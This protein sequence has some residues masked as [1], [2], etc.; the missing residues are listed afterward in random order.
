MPEK[1]QNTKGVPDEETAITEPGVTRKLPEN[2]SPLPAEDKFPGPPDYTR[3]K[4]EHLLGEKYR[5]EQF[6][7]KGAFAA[8]YKV[9]NLSL[10]RIEALK[11]LL[12]TKHNQPD[13][14]K[15]FTQ[16]ARVSASLDHPNI[17]RVF[18][19]G[20]TT[21]LFWF[22]MEYIDGPTLAEELSSRKTIGEIQAA[23]LIRPL[24]DALEYSHNRGVIHRDI[25]PSNIMLDMCGLPHLMDFGIAKS[26]GS[27]LQTRTGQYLGTPVYMAPEQVSE[28]K[29][30]DNR[31]DIY[32]LG[33][34]LYELLAGEYPFPADDPVQ[35]L[36]I[37]LTNDPVPLSDVAPG[38]DPKLK[39]V[40]MRALEKDPKKRFAT[41]SEMRMHLDQFL[42]DKYPEPLEI[43]KIPQKPSEGLTTVYRGSSENIATVVSPQIQ[44]KRSKWQRTLGL[45][46]ILIAV[47]AVG[48]M[49][50]MNGKGAEPDRNESPI[51]RPAKQSLPPPAT[52]PANEKTESQKQ[53]LTR[54]DG[55]KSKPEKPQ[56]TGPNNPDAN[57]PAP[58]Q[59]KADISP[60]RKPEPK[61]KPVISRPVT[62][63]VLIKEATPVFPPDTGSNC[64]GLT[65]NLSL[66]INKEGKVL[67]ARVIS[68][69]HP[70]ECSPALNAVKEAVL[71][72][73][74]EPA[75][76]AN[77]NPTLAAMAIAVTI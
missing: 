13:F 26:T 67:K 58:V 43:T 66:V 42:V 53:H 75:L 17:V 15:R 41:V 22:S 59:K 72:N 71:K 52:P 54:E 30:V 50:L 47:I 29:S 3:K 65:I 4:L 23:A 8:V 63:P 9:T 62:M 32:A 35:S 48:V 77:G 74:Y 10:N 19:Y 73:I 38:I 21:D 31:A 70:P 49:L 40:T 34:M 76:D 14:A 56:I 60:Q 57:K 51:Q 11:V 61:P 37:R 36:V 1:K 7:G 44:I 68:T 27:L 5:I 24:L 2:F 69:G 39:F 20:H 16:E 64:S 18:D 28:R 6:L 46:I 12:D 45:A 25:K 33:V 55:S